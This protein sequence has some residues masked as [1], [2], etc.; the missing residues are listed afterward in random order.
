MMAERG[1][2]VDHANNAS[3][4][5][6]EAD[7]DDDFSLA[8]LAATELPLNHESRLAKA[9]ASTRACMARSLDLAARCYWLY[10]RPRAAP[11]FPIALLSRQ[12]STVRVFT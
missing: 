7:K 4:V 12:N 8:Q 10:P 2:S 9:S 1:I 11:I 6:L 5:C 3:C